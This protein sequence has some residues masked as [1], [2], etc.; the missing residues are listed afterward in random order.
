MLMYYFDDTFDSEFGSRI[1]PIDGDITDDNLSHVLADYDFDTVIN[2]AAC[3]KHFVNDDLL[4]R[5][6]VHGV[7]NLIN[8]C[9]ERNKKLIQV[10]TVS[11]AGESVNNSIPKDELLTENRLYF[12]QSLDNKYAETKFRAEKKVLEAVRGG[13]KGKV[14]RVG[15][16]MSRE[17]DGEF[18][19]NYSTNGFMKRLRA[20]AMIGSFPVD[21]LDSPAEFSPIDCTAKAV[22]TLAGTPDKFTVFHAYNCHHVHMANV[23]DVMRGYGI[24][25]DVVSDDEFNKKFNEMLAD[26]KRNMEISSLISY[27]SAGSSERRFV[28][29]DNSFTIKAL[30]RLGFA[31]PLTGEKYI[32]QAVNALYTLGF[33]DS[34]YED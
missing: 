9:S 7:E 32:K 17:S 22:I 20:Y 30:Y 10:S 13:L 5:V 14:I 31:W 4:D 11:V 8:I 28:G 2:C 16:L 6:N 1:I 18:Q 19:I 21:S 26:E 34:D 25:I 3:V 29:W 33:F 23:L 27:L 15:N 12:G 24:D